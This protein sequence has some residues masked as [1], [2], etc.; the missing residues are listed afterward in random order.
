M[1]TEVRDG[2]LRPVHVLPVVLLVVAS[3]L[4]LGNAHRSVC[5]P[6][7]NTTIYCFLHLPKVPTKG[8]LGIALTV[9]SRELRTLQNALAKLPRLFSEILVDFIMTP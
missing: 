4:F 8:P 6:K 2:Y 3:W 5:L 7:I 1:H 9:F